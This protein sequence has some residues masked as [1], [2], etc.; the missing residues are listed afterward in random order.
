MNNQNIKKQLQAEKLLNKTR[1][2]Y[3]MSI[4]HVKTEAEFKKQV[5]ESTVPV[6]VD[7][8]ADWCP[9][10]RS[11]GKVFE[12]VIEDSNGWNIVKLN[13]DDAG[14]KVLA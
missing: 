8:Y 6:I 1:K 3:K 2:R 14:V 7:F 5:L 12:A 4:I 10:C 13:C 11:L 9:P